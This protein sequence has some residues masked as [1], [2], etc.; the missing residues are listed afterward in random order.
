MKK[1]HD[2][3]KWLAGDMTA[4]ERVDFEKSPE[5]SSY[6]KIARASQF[7]EAPGFDADKMYQGI[8]SRE[9]IQPRVIPLYRKNLLLK[10]AAVL[11]IGLGIWFSL[12]QT[13]QPR[14]QELAAAGKTS[15]FSLPD[16]SEVTLNADSEAD[17]SSNDWDDN[18]KINLRGEAFFKVA[19]GKTFDV[20]TDCGKV[21]VVGTQFNVKSRGQRFEVT[22]FEGKVRVQCGKNTTFI[23]KGQKVAFE[24]GQPI[25]SQ[26]MA[27]DRPSWMDRQMEFTSENLQGVVAE[28]KRQYNVEIEVTGADK[29]KNLA[30]TGVM[31]ADK[32]EVAL[33]IVSRTFGIHVKKTESGIIL[34][35]N[36]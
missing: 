8:I 19:K 34:S 20:L 12:P 24:N 7:L 36:E 23:T 10:I 28:M 1:E 17:Y 29:T 5:F 21:T 35:G 27:S 30:F 18:R 2:L 13:D 26:F 11:V 33:E 6:D 32:L 22:C 3:A 15:V 25:P 9:K 16:H 4:E 31:P 14:H